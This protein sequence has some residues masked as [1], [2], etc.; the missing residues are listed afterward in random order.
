M[1][2]QAVP[3]DLRERAIPPLISTMKIHARAIPSRRHQERHLR[4]FQSPPRRWHLLQA[5]PQEKVFRKSTSQRAI[6]LKLSPSPRPQ[7]LK[8][9]VPLKPPNPSSEKVHLASTTWPRTPPR[10]RLQQ[11]LAVPHHPKPPQDR[12]PPA[13]QPLRAIPQALSFPNTCP[14]QRTQTTTELPAQ[15][16]TSLK[17]V[18]QPMKSICSPSYPATK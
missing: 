4:Q 8:R 9:A 15:N 1:K 10:T 7:Q 12:L 18:K 17:P 6:P 11:V 13:P 2:P 3:R 16:R 14:L 5:L